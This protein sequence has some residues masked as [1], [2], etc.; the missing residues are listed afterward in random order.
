MK[1][2]ANKRKLFDFIGRNVC[3]LCAWCVY[4][5]HARNT[6]KILSFVASATFAIHDSD[7]VSVMLLF[8]L[9]LVKSKCIYASPWYL[10]KEWAFY[11]GLTR[12]YTFTLAHTCSAHVCRM[13]WCDVDSCIDNFESAVTSCINCSH[14]STCKCHRPISTPQHTY[15]HMRQYL[16]EFRCGIFVPLRQYPFQTY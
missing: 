10:H 2:S 16:N 6:R 9:L 5:V 3:V 4:Y 8:F 14:N 7:F 13:C 15:N 11:S 1:Q 12:R